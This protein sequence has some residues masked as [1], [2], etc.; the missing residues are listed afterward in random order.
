MRS[1]RC[2]F[3]IAVA[4][5]LS[6]LATTGLA[7]DFG[8]DPTA[9]R[10]TVYFRSTAKLEFI[11][12]KSNNIEGRF[13]VD[14]NHVDS[15]VTGL[16]RVD[17]RTLKTGIETRD[18]H[19]RDRHLHTDKYP[20]AFFEVDS[21][22]GIPQRLDAGITH[23]GKVFGFFYIHGVR[24]PL[25]ASFEATR[26]SESGRE[27]LT[28]QTK[29]QLDLDDY[30]IPR[31]KALFLKLAE[32]INVECIFSGYNNLAGTAIELPAWLTRE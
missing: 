14:P 1:P 7:A 20:Y 8:L 11:E 15:G 24:R 30:G 13:S 31:P 2:R 22:T 19:M 4:S 10:D 17:L 28:I 18:G 9:S 21:V 29:F 32:T 5:A 23:V 12:G 27:K 16:L 26:S 3:L 6:L 25:E